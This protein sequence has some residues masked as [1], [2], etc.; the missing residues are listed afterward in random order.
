VVATTCEAFAHCV[1]IGN[2]IAAS[3]VAFDLSPEAARQ[4]LSQHAQFAS[5]SDSTFDSWLNRWHGSVFASPAQGA[6][7]ITD[8]RMT[9]EFRRR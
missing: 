8:D 7:I 2:V 6:K 5:M 3:D 1:R 9:D 4:R